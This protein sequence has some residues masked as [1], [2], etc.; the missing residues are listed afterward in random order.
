MTPYRAV[1]GVDVFEFD[2]ALL[3]R[4]RVDDEPEELGQRLREVH[5]LLFPRGE[6]S[7]EV[8]ARV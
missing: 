5:A 4:Y 3:Q 6:R 8:A 1:F 2:S 7:R